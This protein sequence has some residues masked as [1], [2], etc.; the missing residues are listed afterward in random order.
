MED[1]IRAKK[2]K[3]ASSKDVHT[4]I[5]RQ[6]EAKKAK[7][8]LKK[9]QDEEEKRKT[10]ELAEENRQKLMK[11]FQILPQSEIAAIYEECDHDYDKTLNELLLLVAIVEQEN[12]ED[13]GKSKHHKS[14][15]KKLGKLSILVCISVANL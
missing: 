11:R 3:T 12:D 9:Q 14:A 13:D 2:D 15:R 4:F 6:K 8:A 10:E 7:S 1:T 5:A